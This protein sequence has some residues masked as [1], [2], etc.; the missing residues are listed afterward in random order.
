MCSSRFP[1]LDL[2]ETGN[3]FLPSSAIRWFEGRDNSFTGANALEH[4]YITTDDSPK[5]N[6]F[7]K[8]IAMDVGT[9]SSRN[10]NSFCNTVPI[11]Y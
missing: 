11:R 2:D 7:E 10:D 4:F 6:Y 5:D 8:V 9:G 1:R 3:Q